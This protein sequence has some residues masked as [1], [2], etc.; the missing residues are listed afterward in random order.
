MSIFKD[1]FDVFSTRPEAA[2][3]SRHDI[4]Q[5]TRNRVLMW[6]QE[7]FSNSRPDSGVLPGPNGLR[8]IARAGGGDYRGEF[9]QEIYRRLLLRSGRL[10]LSQS[11]HG[12]DANEAIPHVLSC[13]GEEFLDFLQDIFKVECYSH[14]GLPEDV[15]VDELNELLRH[16]NLPYHVTHFVKE[17]VQEGDGR[18]T[19]YTRAYPQVVM[20]ESEVLHA[21]AIAPALTLLGRPH[22][23]GA[24]KEYLAALED[25]RKGDIGDCLTKCGSSFESVLK[26]ICDRKGWRYTQTDTAKTLINIVLP[27]TNLDTYFETLLM[28]VATLRNKLSTAH[29][30]GTAVKQPAPHL[31]QY[32]LNATASAILLIAQETGEY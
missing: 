10:Q 4:P 11:S 32:A 1:I 15:V 23:R 9:W 16:D 3:K 2:S 17:T 14:V 6:C 28:I 7:I 8:M 24:S 22:F 25:Y 27:H 29:G 12:P 18:Y 31:G 21:N 19:I 5:T 26:V 20:K 30:A 13:P